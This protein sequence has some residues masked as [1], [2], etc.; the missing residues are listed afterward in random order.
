MRS[1]LRCCCHYRD[2]HVEAHF[3]C[4]KCWHVGPDELLKSHR[5]LSPYRARRAPRT[6]VFLFP[7]QSHPGKWQASRGW[8]PPSV[9]LPVPMALPLREMIGD[10]DLSSPCHASAAR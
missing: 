9:P 5:W 4:L 8:G 7:A 3:V 1:D 6:S 10:P 2:L